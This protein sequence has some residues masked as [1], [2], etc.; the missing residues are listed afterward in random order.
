MS[1][2]AFERGT[3]PHRTGP[4]GGHDADGPSFAQPTASDGAAIWRLVRTGGTLEPNSA[5]AYVLTGAHFGA[6]S[7]VARRRGEIAGFVWA[8][9]L[10]DRPDTVFVWQIGVAESSRGL[11][12][13]SAMLREIL[14]R[15]ACGGVS[16]LEATVT[17]S[18]AASMA[19]FRGF[20]RRQ[21][22]AFDLSAGF[23]SRLFPDPKHES[24]LL[25]RIGPIPARM[26]T[27]N[28]PKEAIS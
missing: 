22:C 5:Y 9:R 21:G 23:D 18:N 19:L 1:D 25:V 20:A 24:E 12:L 8:Y 27:G 28:N 26:R 4:A 6:T 13:G 17:P 3:D 15:P 16:F 14:H 11:G 7:V 2:T 10:P